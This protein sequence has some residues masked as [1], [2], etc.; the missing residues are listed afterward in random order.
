MAVV[1]ISVGEGRGIAHAAASVMAV[2]TKQ[3]TLA[4][5]WSECKHSDMC[6]H[7]ADCE[8]DDSEDSITRSLFECY[9]CTF[10]ECGVCVG[11]SA[12][13]TLYA[14]R[15]ICSSCRSVAAEKAIV[16]SA[17]SLE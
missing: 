13:Q 5:G 11:L 3:P 10:S 1:P 8:F 14:S 12:R 7:G 15:F 4:H 17:S 16:L 6:W 9:Y 2:A